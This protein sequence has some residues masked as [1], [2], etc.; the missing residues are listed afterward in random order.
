MELRSPMIYS[1][2]RPAFPAQ[3]SCPWHFSHFHFPFFLHSLSLSLLSF[4]H[5]HFQ[6]KMKVVKLFQWEKEEDK[7]SMAKHRLGGPA[8]KVTH[9]SILFAFFSQHFI[10]ETVWLLVCQLEGKASNTYL[11]KWPNFFKLT[12]Q[13]LYHLHQFPHSAVKSANH[14]SLTDSVTHHTTYLSFF[15]TSTIFSSKIWHK[16]C[17]NRKQN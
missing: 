9:D 8:P 13:H 4:S 12:F 14:H 7:F 17:V 16:K 6:M 3:C 5:F 1:R 2:Q 10:D 15:D 11:I